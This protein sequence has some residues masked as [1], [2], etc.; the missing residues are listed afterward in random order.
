MI[1]LDNLDVSG[2]D[3]DQFKAIALRLKVEKSMSNRKI[4]DTLG[5]NEKTIRRW[6]G[7][8]QQMMFQTDQQPWNLKGDYVICGD[9]HADT[10]DFEMLSTMIEWAKRFGVNKLIIAGDLFS[11][12]RTSE[13]IPEGL[14]SGF[15][16]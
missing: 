12:S 11:F 5:V 6:L 3:R 14:F 4:A 9:L 7:K 10:C 15:A 1:D 2:V 16:A 13:Q 8:K